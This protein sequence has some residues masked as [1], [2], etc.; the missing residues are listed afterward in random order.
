MSAAVVTGASGFLGSRLV[1]RLV[2]DGV[3]VT[4]IVRHSTS[5]G[6]V[7]DLTQPRAIDQFLTPDTTVFHLAASAN[8]SASVVDP[9]Y[10]FQNTL[11]STFQVLESA[12]RMGSRVVFT[13]STCVFDLSNPLPFK[14]EGLFRP[15]SPYG[16]AKLAGEGY[17]FAYHRS[18]GLDARVARITNVYGPGMRRFVI[19]DLVMKMRAN[20]R[21]IT[22]IG[23]G[24]QVRDY[25][26]VDDA[27]EA[28]L[29]VARRGR[30]GADYNVGSGR[31]VQL[32]E[33][34]RE[35]AEIIGCPDIRVH[36]TKPMIGDVARMYV[37]TE[38]L[39]SIGFRAAVP[40]RMGLRRTVES[41]LHSDLE[42]IA[43]SRD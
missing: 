21:E 16:A 17:C 13:S 33:V 38:K 41:L 43:D 31:P 39:L 15:A 6:I 7:A 9:V 4:P 20:R 3:P 5:D 23:D 12:R 32:I 10:D 35:I 8:V 40:F 22:I 11:L 36:T 14:E 18:Y 19:A 42:T 2:S 27:V 37:E 25:L 24:S 26:Y 28:L 1:Q 30:A 34:L 29:A